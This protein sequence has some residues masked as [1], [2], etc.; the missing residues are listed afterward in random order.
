[1]A[2]IVFSCILLFFCL[3]I[4]LVFDS[5]IYVPSHLSSHPFIHLPLHPRFVVRIQS[6][7]CIVVCIHSLLL[8]HHPSIHLFTQPPIHPSTHPTSTEVC[9]SN[10]VGWLY[11]VGHLL[12]A[13]ATTSRRRLQTQRMCVRKAYIR[14]RSRLGQ[15]VVSTHKRVVGGRSW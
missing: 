5:S 7:G 8:L 12:L 6:G 1:M 3:F 11:L 13:P 2:Q 10:P 15:D 14:L 9:G 4:H